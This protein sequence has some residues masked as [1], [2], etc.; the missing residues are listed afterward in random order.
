MPFHK[1]AG[2]NHINY[3]EFLAILLHLELVYCENAVNKLKIFLV[4]RITFYVF[5]LCLLYN[6]SGAERGKCVL[7]MTNSILSGNDL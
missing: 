2:T 5:P 1:I 7:G 3:F 6:K 4:S